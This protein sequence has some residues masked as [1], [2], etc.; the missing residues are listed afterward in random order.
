MYN[1]AIV[2]WLALKLRLID[3]IAAKAMR[4]NSRALVALRVVEAEGEPWEADGASG[5]IGRVN[6]W[7]LTMLNACCNRANKEDQ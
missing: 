6:F 1:V 4:A 7:V 5:D 3:R 2:T